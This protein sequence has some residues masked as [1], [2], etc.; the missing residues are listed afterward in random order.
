MILVLGKARSH[1]APNWDCSGVESPGRFHVS[2]KT[3]PAC[4]VM[5]EW[6]HCHDEA[7]NSQLPIAAAFWIIQ[8]LSTEEHSSLMKTLMQIRCSTCSVILNA[9]DTQ[10]TC[11]LNSVYCPQ[12]PAQWSC[13]C[14]RMLIPVHSPWLPGSINVVQTILIMLIMAGLFP[15]RLIYYTCLFVHCLSSLLGGYRFC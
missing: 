8:I 7:A 3:L 12:W 13:H 9:M 10:Y 15:D 5:R 11:S 2:P 1:R 6:E 14:S 4:H